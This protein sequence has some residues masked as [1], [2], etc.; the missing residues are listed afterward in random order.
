MLNHIHKLITF[1]T[2]GI[3]SQLLSFGVLD[4][5]DFFGAKDIEFDQVETCSIYLL[6]FDFSLCQT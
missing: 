3:E 5:A 4:V 2:N 6:L 1:F